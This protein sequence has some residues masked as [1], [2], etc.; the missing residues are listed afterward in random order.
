MPALLLMWW[1]STGEGREAEAPEVPLVVETGAPEVPL[2]NNEYD[3]APGDLS[4]IRTDL[5]AT[6]SRLKMSAVLGRPMPTAELVVQASQNV[7][8]LQARPT[9]GGIDREPTVTRVDGRDFRVQVRVEDGLAPGTHRGYVELKTCLD[10]A[11]LSAVQRGTLYVPFEV[12][13]TDPANAP[14]GEWETFQRDAGHTGYVPATFRPRSFAYKWEWRRPTSGTL[15][16]INAVTTAPGLVFV[17]DDEYHGSPSLRALREENG[18][19]AWQQVF[20]NFPALNPPA[21]AS[22]KVYVATTG[23]QQTFLWAFDAATGAPVFQ[24]AFAGQW[25][26]VLAPTVRDGRVYTNGGYYGGGVYAY[27]ATG[28]DLEWSMFSGDDDMTTPAVDESRVY[29]YDGTALVTYDTETGQRLSITSDPYAPGQGYSHHGAPMLGLPDSVTTFS[30]G[31]FSGRASS[32][33]EQFGARWL[34][35][36]SVKNNVARWRTSRG[37]ITQPA[38]AKGV[39]YAGSNLPKSF[40]AIDEATG[41]VLWSWVP[42]PSDLSFHRNVIV[43]DNLVFVST[44]R[45]IYAIDLVTRQPIWSYPTPGMMAI[46]GSGTLY[47]VEGAREPTGRLIAI[48]LK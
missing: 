36:F 15:G 17:S 27:H 45:A 14:L 19:E 42:P 28:G 7:A 30:G 4:T 46:S 5:V 18:V 31:A 38:T 11:C 12:L 13:V 21:A 41:Q 48:S 39:I 16:F 9:A 1:V 32:S 35:N 20:P 44:N 22:G 34:I 47:I 40:D 6:P 25:P 23:H 24:N 33:V 2:L 3:G 10:D 26:H 43:T 29:F 8:V 37:Y